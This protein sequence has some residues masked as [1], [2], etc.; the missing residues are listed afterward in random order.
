MYGKEAIC[1]CACCNLSSQGSETDLTV[2]TSQRNYCHYLFRL[3]LPR[4][5][6]LTYPT[7]SVA[8]QTYSNAQFEFG[9]I[10]VI[11]RIIN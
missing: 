7:A 11:S 5:W 4:E 9:S 10:P 8:Q 6:L 2:W 1:D 3:G